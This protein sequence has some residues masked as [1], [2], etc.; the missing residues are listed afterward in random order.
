MAIVKRELEDFKLWLELDKAPATASA[1]YQSVS[2]LLNKYG[3][4]DRDTIIRFVAG[5]KNKRSA[6][7]HG[8]AI[9][10]YLHFIGNRDLEEFVPIPGYQTK[11]PKWLEEEQIEGLYRNC[12]SVRDNCVI[13]LGYEL[14]LRAGELCLLN[15]SDISIG[16]SI[17]VH[18][19]KGKKGVIE[20]Q[21]LPMGDKLS[22]WVED[23]LMEKSA[24]PDD[25]GVPLLTTNS[26][27][28]LN[29]GNVSKIFKRIIGR[30]GVNATFHCLRHSRLTHLAT[31]GF[32]LT[33]LAELAHHKN[34]AS[35]LI[36]THASLEM[37]RK[38][39]AQ[40]ER[41]EAVGVA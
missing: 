30:I 3:K 29:R 13:G 32:S 7:R 10:K 17:N 40:L 26:G 41:K 33:E 9:R 15:L 34:P 39:I 37:L 21:V 20:D 5:F 1:Y 16:K 25:Y 19:L 8:Y 28:R 11:A 2:R 14:A 36:Y 24:T 27:K 35:T 31:G 23:Y 6:A 4:I 18:R 22:S 38:R 12:R